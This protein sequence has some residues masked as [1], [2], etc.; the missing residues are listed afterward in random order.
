[1]SRPVDVVGTGAAGREGLTPQAAAAIDRAEVL[2]GGRRQLALFPDVPADRIVLAADLP[3]AVGL[4][5][6]KAEAGRR[7]TV[8]ASGDPLLYGIGATLI[9][10]LGA[11]A[12]RVQPGISSV[13]LAFAR[14]G[15]PWHDATVLSAH[16]RPLE[17]IVPEA[18]AGSKLAILTD[19]RATPAAISLALTAAG[20]EDCRALICERLGEPRERLVE[21]T[22]HALTGQAFDPLNLLLLLR[23]PASVR[24]RFGQPDEEFESLHGQITKAEVR[25]VTLSK[26]DLPP[27][28]VLWDVGA[29]SGALAI[30]AARLMPR[31][32]VYAVERDADQRGCLERNV[33]RHHASNVRVVAGE[34]PEALSDLARPQ[35][36][37]IGGSGGRLSDLLE[38]VAPPFVINLAVLEHVSTVLKR[39]PQAEATQ[40]GVSRS[41]EIGDGHRMSAL[42]PVYIVAVPA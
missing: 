27:N 23:D 5:R 32:T 21:T 2:A 13:Q 8:L 24:L 42:N 39:Y 25:A 26:L 7:V 38:A 3:G 16:G 22:L 40:L 35:S 1:M 19:D 33:A 4:I 10:E 18:L 6:S 31:G 41:S 12:V 9:R 30:E 28:G 20:M 11:E 34:A 36:T 17:S 37:F 29:G 15:L 14:A